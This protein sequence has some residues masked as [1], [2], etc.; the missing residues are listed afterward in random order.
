MT[1]D[2]VFG[3]F[4]LIL[5]LASLYSYSCGVILL[6]EAIL[7]YCKDDLLV[8]QDAYLAFFN[9]GVGIFHGGLALLAN[10]LRKK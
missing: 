10:H 2:T 1:R 6:P 3:I 4:I 7:H 9:M 8:N 5:L